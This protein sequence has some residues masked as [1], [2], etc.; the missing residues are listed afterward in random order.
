MK[1]S[2][3][4][5]SIDLN[6]LYHG[7][8]RTHLPQ[9]MSRGLDPMSSNYA[10]DEEANDAEGFGPPYHFVYL[11]DLETA[12]KFAAGG[13]H[14]QDN[15]KSNMVILKVNLPPDLQGKLILDRGEFIRAPFL[16]E[17]RFISIVR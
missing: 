4:S 13:E 12:S 15:D 14:S 5:E 17:P 16:I 1:L 7:T 2:L 6:T 8:Y 11:S 9:I 3:I 10:D